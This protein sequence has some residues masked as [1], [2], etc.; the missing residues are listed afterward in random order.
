MRSSRFPQLFALL[1]AVVIPL[2]ITNSDDGLQNRIVGTW[3]E[4]RFETKSKAVKESDYRVTFAANGLLKLHLKK[5]EKGDQRALNGTWEMEGDAKLKMEIVA[6]GEKNEQA[7]TVSFEGDEMVFTDSDGR[8]TWHSR[9]E[10]PRP[11]R[12]Q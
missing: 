1:L 4:K 11:E 5:G 7:M 10:G 2:Q 8:R 6:E 3:P 9:H 12:H